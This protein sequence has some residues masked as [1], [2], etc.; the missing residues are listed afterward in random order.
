MNIELE[1][2]LRCN[3][4]CKCCNRHCNAFDFMPLD[5]SDMTLHQIDKFCS[6][7]AESRHR[8]DRISVMGGEPLLHP[9][10]EA[11][12]R[13]LKQRL[14]KQHL[15]RELQLATNGDLLKATPPRALEYAQNRVRWTKQEFVDMFCA[16]IDLDRQ[17]HH[18]RVPHYC[19]IALNCWGYWP[20]GP[21]G[22]IAR[23]FNLLQFQRLTL[24]AGFKAFGTTDANG[25]IP[26][27]C[28]YCQL[29][30]SHYILARKGR[31]PT[32]SF[33]DAIEQ[34]KLAPVLPTL[35]RF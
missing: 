9:Q 27:I 24:P 6:Q 34:Y 18:C 2:T 11:I 8:L 17:R 3:R 7:V 12:M 14:V 33:I 16:P 26:G 10:I 20:C 21:G 30:T 22:A 25:N 4:A 19:G 5:D 23:L 1:I 15:V 29:S 31:G 32:Q 13:M 28:D 35:A